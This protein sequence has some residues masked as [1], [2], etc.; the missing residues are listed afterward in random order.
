[1]KPI[2]NPPKI[3]L[4]NNIIKIQKRLDN[5]KIIPREPHIPSALERALKDTKYGN[6]ELLDNYRRDTIQRIINGSFESWSALGKKILSTLGIS[7]DE[8]EKLRKEAIELSKKVNPE[9]I[10]PREAASNLSRLFQHLGLREAIK[11]SATVYSFGCGQ[12]PEAKACLNYFSDRLGRFV[13]YDINGAKL[14]FAKSS[15]QDPRVSFEERDL[16]KSLPEDRPGLIIVR[17]P[18]IYLYEQAGQNT[19][20][21]AW[22]N[23]LQNIRA[24]YP[25]SSV[26]ITALSI[27]EAKLA[28]RW[29]GIP[30]EKITKNPFSTHLKAT[31]DKFGTFN[32][33]VAADN[34]YVLKR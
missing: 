7:L 16:S 14:A 33:P 12:C 17:N 1:M 25:E 5:P 32:L 24:K 6:T 10:D 22:Q 13:G 18:N 28:S 29:L 27:E 15:N 11:G 4:D 26:L 23:I 9:D 30:E 20:N 3:F 19:P 8:A 2:D 21:L 31:F 34:L